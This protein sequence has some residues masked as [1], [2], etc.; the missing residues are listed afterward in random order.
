MR[1]NYF[2]FHLIQNILL[3]Q[4]LRAPPPPSACVSKMSD[5][6]WPPPPPRQ[7]MSEFGRPPPPPKLADVINERPLIG[8]SDRH[9]GIWLWA[10]SGSLSTSFLPCSF[11]DFSSWIDWPGWLAKSAPFWVVSLVSLLR[12]S[13]ELFW[14]SW[15]YAA[16]AGDDGLAGRGPGLSCK[17][18]ELVDCVLNWLFTWDGAPVA[19]C[20]TS[21][22]FIWAS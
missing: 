1:T 4:L 5:F 19:P 8:W 7:Q 14:T 21:S 2:I 11:G 16:E 20:K 22:E 12:P 9:L 10:P 13:S 17:V 15:L 3:Y 6:Y 18:S